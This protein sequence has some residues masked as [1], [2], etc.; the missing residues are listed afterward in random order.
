MAENT[1]AG[2]VE[3]TQCE[4]A[5]DGMSGCEMSRC[6]KYRYSLWRRW[7]PTDPLLRWMMLNPSTADAS[8]DDPTIRKCIG[9]ARRL[10]FGGIQVLNLFA[11]RATD[12]KALF[13]AADP[14]GPDYTLRGLAS[15]PIVCAWGAHKMAAARGRKVAS[16][17]AFEHGAQSPLMCLGKTKDGHPKHPLYVPYEAALQAY[18]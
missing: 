6:G 7:H 3:R 12:P 2:A 5:L 18:P 1:E 15:G 4:V 13:T 10:G 9:F 16:E 11:L 14:I 17:I 8:I